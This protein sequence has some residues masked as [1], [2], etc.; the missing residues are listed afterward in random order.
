MELI[1]KLENDHRLIDRAGGSL[2]AWW[3]DARLGNAEAGDLAGYV[4]FFSRYLCGPHH[5]GEEII[6]TTLADRAEVPSRHGPIAVLRHE[7]QRLTDTNEELS[8]LVGRSDDFRES[9][10]EIVRGL[11]HLL[12]EHIDKESSVLLPQALK[13]LQHHG[14]PH[15]DPP[16]V[17]EDEKAAREIAEALVDRYE[18][19]DD[20]D[21]VRG[22]GCMA[23]SEF[24]ESCH[25]IEAEW[26]TTWERSHYRSLDDG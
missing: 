21:V 17:S 8:Q 16:K 20:P 3:A 12:W 7:H 5:R 23:C 24:A 13:R 15:L 26:W 10:D 2:L 22:D 11:V 6:F 25:G 1:T 19:I 14:V 4:E 18:P 9:D